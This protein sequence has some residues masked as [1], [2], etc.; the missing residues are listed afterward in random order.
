MQFAACLS[1]HGAGD[2]YEL[3]FSQV[4]VLQKGVNDACAFAKA[5]AENRWSVNQYLS[6]GSDCRHS[7]CASAEQ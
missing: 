4:H 3:F 1:F 6:F 5:R 2:R 7:F